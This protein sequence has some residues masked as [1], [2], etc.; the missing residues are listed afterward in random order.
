MPKRKGI[1]S[2]EIEDP[3]RLLQGALGNL[4]KSLAKLSER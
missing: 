4:G 1:T 2:M 3:G